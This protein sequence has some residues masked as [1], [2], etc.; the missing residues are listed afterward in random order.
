MNDFGLVVDNVHLK[1]LAKSFRKRA[2]AMDKLLGCNDNNDDEKTSTVTMLHQGPL[3]IRR[4]TQPMNTEFAQIHYDSRT[5]TTVPSAIPNKF[6]AL[7]LGA[8]RCMNLRPY[9]VEVPILPI[10]SREHL[11]LGEQFV[12]ILASSMIHQGGFNNVEPG[13]DEL[14]EDIMDQKLCREAVDYLLQTTKYCEQNG[15]RWARDV[16]MFGKIAEGPDTG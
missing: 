16:A 14:T 4:T 5:M 7:T 10:T 2:A 15:D 13:T 9:T 12:T 3:Y 8:L 11:V 1:A 6:L